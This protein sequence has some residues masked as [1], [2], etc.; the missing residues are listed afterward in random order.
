M[1]GIISYANMEN[2]WTV[3]ADVASFAAAVSEAA[4]NRTL[5]AQKAKNALATSRSYGWENVAPTFLELYEELSRLNAATSQAPASAFCSTPAKGVQ[6]ALMRGVA[7]VAK[8]SFRLWLRF[9]P[10]SQSPR[11]PLGAKPEP[12]TAAR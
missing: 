2:A 1:G 6:A 3:N 5:A 9:R 12:G 4:T 11:P 8:S 7:Y 10:N